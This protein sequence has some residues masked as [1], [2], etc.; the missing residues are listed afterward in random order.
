M[1]IDNSQVV[2]ENSTDTVIDFVIPLHTVSAL[3]VLRYRNLA[4][5]SVK[6]E[7]VEEEEGEEDSDSVSDPSDLSSGDD[8]VGEEIHF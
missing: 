1:E 2:I 4:V 7:D 3:T 6:K 8:L 5:S